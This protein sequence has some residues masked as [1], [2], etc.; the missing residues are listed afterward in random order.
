MEVREAYMY[1]ALQLAS[2]GEG[3][4]LSNPMVGAVI[5][6]DDKIIGEGFHRRWGDAH[7]EVNAVASV[8]DKS[9]LR[10]S[11]MYVTL[12][13]CS[14]YGKTPPCAELIIR[15][16]IPRVVVGV[17]D[18][19]EKVRGRGVEM[20][21]RAGVEVVSGVLESECCELNKRFIT[22]HTK[23]RPYVL[24]KWAESSDGFI[25]KENGEP[26]MLSNT[27]SKMWV[28]KERSKYDAIMVGTNTVLTDDP[29][30]TV[31]DWPG[32]NPRCVTFNL[33]E[34][35]PKDSR[36]MQREDTIVVTDD[37]A[38][39]DLLSKLYSEYGITSL[40][41]EGGAKLIND[42]IKNNCYDEVRIEVSPM[43]LESG[44]KSPSIECEKV[45]S[46]IVRTNEIWQKRS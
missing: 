14:H 17:L 41:V 30:L 3:R 33:H 18:P 38:I 32:R 36:V 15:C 20:L 13:P 22:A 26:V 5:V 27:L 4:V 11:T 44:I 12:E 21:R 37:I 46:E 6:C 19:F 39:P 24:L 45:L 40:I 9:L 25:S 1:R 29:Q 7:A 16:G 42:F 34:R 23:R 35:L 31:R 43:R 28:H 10:Q 2:K 8:G